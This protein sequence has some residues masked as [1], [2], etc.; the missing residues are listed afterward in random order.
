MNDFQHPQPLSSPP[1]EDDLA[2]RI[3]LLKNAGDQ[4]GALALYKEKERQ[5]RDSNDI[6]ELVENLKSQGD[7]LRERGDW[8][9]SIPIYLEAE[10]ICRQ[11]EAPHRLQTVLNNHGI[12]LEDLGDLEEAERHFQESEN[13]CRNLQDWKGVRRCLFNRARV[14]KQREGLD[15]ALALYQEQEPFWRTLEHPEQLARFLGDEAGRFA[16]S[17][18]WEKAL[19]LY[20]EQEQ[21]FRQIGKTNGLKH[22]LADQVRILK[23]MELLDAALPLSKEHEQLCRQLEDREGILWSLTSQLFILANLGEHRSALALFSE[24]EK[25]CDE[26]KQ[27]DTLQQCF[28]NEAALFEQLH[29]EANALTAYKKQEQI[30]RQLEDSD[31][32]VN[33]LGD[34]A[35]ILEKQD[36]FEAASALYSEREQLCSQLQDLKRLQGCFKEHALL[37]K[38][39][40][41]NRGALAL[42]REEEKLCRQGNTIEDLGICLGNQALVLKMESEWDGAVALLKEKQQ[43]CRDL[44]NASSLIWSIHQEAIILMK[45]DDP[46]GALALFKEEETICRQTDNLRDLQSALD[47]QA[48]ILSKRKRLDD[49]LVLLREQEQICRQ[50]KYDD[51]LK[52]S[53]G[54]QAI[55]LAKLEKLDAALALHRQEEEICRRINNSADLHICLGNQAIVLKRMGDTQSS[56]EM[57]REKADICERLGRFSG[58][59]WSLKQQASIL[60]ERNELS[61]ALSALKEEEKACRRLNKSILLTANLDSQSRLLCAQRELRE[62]LKSDD[63]KESLN[64]SA[65]EISTATPPAHASQRRLVD[66]IRP[67]WVASIYIVCILVIIPSVLVLCGFCFAILPL[68]FVWLLA[69]KIW[70]IWRSGWRALTARHIFHVADQRT[71]AILNGTRR[72]LD[73]SIQFSR[74][75]LRLVSPHFI[76]QSLVKHVDA[77]SI[78]GQTNTAAIQCQLVLALADKYRNMDDRRKCRQLLVQCMAADSLDPVIRQECENLLERDRDITPKLF[79]AS[80]IALAKH[81]AQL[82]STRTHY[83]E[84]EILHSVESCLSPAE[85]LSQWAEAKNLLGVTYWKR[86]QTSKSDSDLESAIKHTTDCL[87]VLNEDAHPALWALAHYN[88][89]V[90]YAAPTSDRPQGDVERVIESMECALRVYTPDIPTYID[91]QIRLM[92]ALS[93]RSKGIES[94]NLD[95]AVD[96]INAAFSAPNLTEAQRASLERSMNV[97]LQRRWGTHFS[98][99]ASPQYIEAT[100]QLF[101]RPPDNPTANLRSIIGSREQF[102]RKR[103]TLS[104]LK[105]LVI[106]VEIVCVYEFWH[107]PWTLAGIV[108]SISVAY[109]FTAAFMTPEGLEKLTWLPL[110]FIR[111]MPA[112]FW[113]FLTSK[114][115][116]KMRVAGLMQSLVSDPEAAVGRIE[117]MWKAI[118]K[119]SNQ[120]VWALFGSTYAW[121]SLYFP[122][123]EPGE[124][125]HNAIAILQEAGEVFTEKKFSAFQTGVDFSLA[126]A[127]LLAAET[128][129]QNVLNDA[130]DLIT[131]HVMPVRLARSQKKRGILWAQT[132]QLLGDAYVMLA[133][134]GDFEFLKQAIRCY[135]ES[136][137]PQLSVYRRPSQAVRDLLSVARLKPTRAMQAHA[138]KGLGNALL[139]LPDDKEVDRSTLA[140]G[141]LV[142]AY[143]ILEEPRFMSQIGALVSP[144]ERPVIRFEK[145]LRQGRS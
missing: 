26:L 127:Y 105:W 47:Y 31:S 27:P 49:A 107:Q 18:N 2:D 43:I 58:L 78:A 24:L 108:T 9:D 37:L 48:R 50:L 112:L 67:L 115:S 128:G 72:L 121:F 114:D 118:D 55:I 88:L 138:L 35:S 5:L 36:N 113:W 61:A 142:N 135:A 73:D 95:R 120:T 40:K 12:S 144:K 17:K 38:R 130:V 82:G 92:V 104:R 109:I 28:R 93:K 126:K 57:L 100:N 60:E 68:L 69:D 75:S 8:S 116:D 4:D 110:E 52:R 137:S 20:K 106:L 59:Q 25:L 102:D 98:S 14:L 111:I 94:L 87:E 85:D 132:L 32:L 96:C 62:G 83:P 70:R 13:I 41:D 56:L 97:L 79:A 44:G 45:R 74:T 86:W 22:C 122:R 89:G 139:L 39:Q 119:A 131:E 123:G 129:T 51:G 53:L 66:K 99:L 10:K 101:E 91:A 133:S 77:L 15:A 65:Y 6:A 145:L 34:Q 134:R 46:D 143:R 42:F 84:I 141:C 54:D 81:L 124:S 33:C 7:L 11:I 64:A 71:N 16:E 103:I 29:E 117:K 1:P 23:G 63:V 140:F 136:I 80:Q 90:I 30:C 3:Q 19:A 125:I 76:V 21:T